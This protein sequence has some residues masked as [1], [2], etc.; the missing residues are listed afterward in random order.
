MQDPYGDDGV[1][2]TNHFTNEA[3]IRVPTL[4]GMFADSFWVD[5]WPKPTDY[6]AK[7]LYAD[8]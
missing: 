7:D 3:S 8:Y 2:K 4:T 6:A 5:T 1:G